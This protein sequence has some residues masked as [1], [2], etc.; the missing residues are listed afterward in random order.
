MG[1]YL[2]GWTQRQRVKF[3]DFLSESIQCHSGV[4]QGSHVEP[5]FFILDINGALVTFKNVSVLGYAD[6]LKLF[7]TIKCIG[8]CQL[9]QRDLDRLGEWC[10]SNKFDL[11]AG[12]CKLISLHRI[13]PIVFV[14]SIDGTALERVDEIKELG[15]IINGGMFFLPHIEAI[16]SKSSGMLGFFKRISRDFRDLYNHKTLCTSLV[17][18]NLEHAACVWSLHQ[19]VHSVWLAQVQHNFIRYAVRRLPWRMWPLPAY[20]SRRLLIGFQVLSNKKIF[21]SALFARDIL[22]GGVDCADL[23]LMIRFEEVPYS[24]R[25]NARLL[26]FFHRTNYGRFEPVNNRDFQDIDLSFK[27]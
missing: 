4:P 10:P 22:V 24:R 9:F 6:D 23:G 25:R 27:F 26:T 8:D 18:P 20:D 14:Y 11:H 13:R 5:I 17:R 3:E 16:I 2:T 15:V 12:K 1:S 7:M 19:S 21:A